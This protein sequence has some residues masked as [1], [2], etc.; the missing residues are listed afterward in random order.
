MWGTLPG[1]PLLHAECRTSAV[2]LPARACTEGSPPAREGSALG[3]RLLPSA[4]GVR[5]TDV[6]E[7]DSSPTRLNMLP[8][9]PTKGNP[10][11]LE[12]PH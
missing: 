6:P 5:S 11:G 1:Y 10:F 3:L 9:N 12:V 7:A 2:P 4:L 8:S